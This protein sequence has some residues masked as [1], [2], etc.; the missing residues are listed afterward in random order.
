MGRRY[1]GRL[2]C[3]IE[4]GPTCSLISNGSLLEDLPGQFAVWAASEEAKFLHGRFVWAKWDVAELCKGPLRERI[5]KDPEFLQVNV[6][7]M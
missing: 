1:V 7:G 4:E 5:D 6:K 3:L 2:L